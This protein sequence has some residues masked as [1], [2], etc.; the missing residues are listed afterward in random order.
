MRTSW[1]RA[2]FS[3]DR[4]LPSRIEL[5]HEVGTL[6]FGQVLHIGSNVINAIQNIYGSIRQPP[7]CL[8]I[9][10]RLQTNP[11]PSLGQL[12]DEF[13]HLIFDS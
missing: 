11:C 1:Y 2:G 8:L 13:A 5:P 4:L 3:L 10:Y 12:D 6:Q 7:P 9:V